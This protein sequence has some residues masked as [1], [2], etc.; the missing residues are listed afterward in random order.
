MKRTSFRVSKIIHIRAL[1][2]FRK[3]IGA[4]P[5][6]RFTCYACY[7]RQGSKITGWNRSISGRAMLRRK[8]WKRRNP[9]CT[10]PSPRDPS[11]ARSR[12]RQEISAAGP[13]SVV[14]QPSVPRDHF[15]KWNVML[16]LTKNNS[17]L[18]FLSP[19]SVDAVEEKKQVRVIF[20]SLTPPPRSSTP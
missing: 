15:H 13:P 2:F 14:A 12:G 11:R 18:V 8:M 19:S 7:F 16:A 6:V 17:D 20:E 9:H 5:R 4:A 1:R 10:K 3:S